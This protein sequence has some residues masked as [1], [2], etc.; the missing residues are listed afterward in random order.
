MEAGQQEPLPK[1]PESLLRR[2]IL[3]GSKEGDTVLDPFMGSGTTGAVAKQL[4]RNFIGIEKEDF[5]IKIANDR[6]EKIKPL[7]DELL[8]Y[9][10]EEKKPKVPFGNLIENRLINI[11]DYLCSRDGKFKA[12]ILADATLKWNDNI[13]SIHKVSAEILGK[14]SNNG[15]T[16]WHTKDTKNNIILIDEIRNEYIKKYLT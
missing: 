7:S 6:I 4:G 13:G 16:Y 3:I 9:P 15:W 14:V 1:K 8:T 2:I 12:K 10:V 11:G 5:Y